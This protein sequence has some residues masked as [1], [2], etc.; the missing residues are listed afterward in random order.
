MSELF[1]GVCPVINTPFTEDNQIDAPGIA[2]IIEYVIA[3]GSDSIAIFALNSEPHKMTLPEK[4]KTIQHFLETVDK[5]VDT[6]VG[7]VENSLHG[8]IE[9]AELANQNGADGIII[10]PPSLVPASGEQLFK[11]FEAIACAVDCPVMIQDAPKTTG[12]SMTASFLMDVYKKIENVSYV[13]VECPLPVIKIARISQETDGGFKCLSGNGGIYSIDGFVQGAWGVMP[14]VGLVQHFIKMYDYYRKGNLNKAR[15]VFE[16]LMPMLWFEDQSL[17]FFIAC[18]K[19]I[20]K[21]KGIIE[22][23]HSRIPGLELGDANN[24]ELHALMDRLYTF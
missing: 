1:K 6:L 2:N 4:A 22:H 23:S 10:Y 19:E 13:K 17:E 20:L 11:Y 15:D 24:R 9:L 5:R 18:E 14:G 16:N 12:V 7:I 21:Y 8:A 3:S